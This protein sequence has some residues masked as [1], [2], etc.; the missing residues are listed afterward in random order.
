M[1]YHLYGVMGIQIGW[2]TGMA[3]CWGN[4]FCDHWHTVVHII[5]V[6]II[7][8]VPGALDGGGGCLCCMLILI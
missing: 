2:S 3:G 4:V 6:V 8:H 7:I 1:V 5:Q